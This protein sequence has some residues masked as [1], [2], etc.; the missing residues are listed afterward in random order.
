MALILTE[1]SQASL[2]KQTIVS[3]D[4]SGL[5]FPWFLNDCVSSPCILSLV[6]S[7]TNHIRNQ[8]PGPSSYPPMVCRPSCAKHANSYVT[9]THPSHSS[10]AF[11]RPFLLCSPA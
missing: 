9:L 2:R 4:G 3:P 11:S 7:V 6:P 8:C 1:P 10:L 5:W